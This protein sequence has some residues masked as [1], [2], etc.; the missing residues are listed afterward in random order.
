MLVGQ[1]GELGAV[2]LFRHSL[3]TQ[4][5]DSS[6]ELRTENRVVAPL[7]SRAVLHKN[8]YGWIQGIMSD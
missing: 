5:H 1:G 2:G 3:K 4:G 7:H 8:V 6:C